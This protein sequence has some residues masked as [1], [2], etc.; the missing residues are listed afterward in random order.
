MS[1]SSVLGL[2]GTVIGL[3]RALPQ[4]LAILRAK[5][6]SGVS[7]DTAVTSALVGFGWATYG[8]LTSQPFVALA[9]GSSGTV[10]L[11]IAFFSVRFGRS[12]RELKVAPVWVM[13]LV[14][15]FVLK[16]ETGLGLILPVS[17][18]V[19]NIP[20]LYVALKEKDLK[21]LSLGTWLFSVSDGVVWG[22]YSLLE[23]DTA[24]LVF[25]LFQLAT[26]VPIVILK[27]INQKKIQG[28][29]NLPQR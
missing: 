28:R 1:I 29:V 25:A 19:S 13:V 11:F 3:V 17:I 2:F 4:L 21:D 10:F 15:A 18:L 6:A 27:L 26:S 12:P 8:I 22:A 9:T 24:I 23:Q 5:E 20:Q 14:L 7:V 16:R